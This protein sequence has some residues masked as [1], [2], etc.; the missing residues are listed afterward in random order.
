MAPAT[1]RRH[2]WTMLLRLHD[3]GFSQNSIAERNLLVQP[4]PLTVAP[5]LRSLKTP[6]YR[7][8]DFGRGLREKD[9]IDPETKK[10]TAFIK[11]VTEDRFSLKQ[12]FDFMLPEMW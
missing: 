4:G 9:T 3:N 5:H 6:S 8:I 12:I 7:L 2:W 1:Y 11:S 10:R